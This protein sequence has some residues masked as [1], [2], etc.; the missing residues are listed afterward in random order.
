MEREEINEDD[1]LEKI[2]ENKFHGDILQGKFKDSYENVAHKVILSFIWIN[3]Y[4]L[5]D[6]VDLYYQK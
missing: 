4:K 2:T 3:R 5:F 6:F 1:K